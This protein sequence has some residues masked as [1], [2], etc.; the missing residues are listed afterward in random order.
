LATNG[1]K[2]E[3]EREGKGQGK[4]GKKDM[5]WRKSRKYNPNYGLRLMIYFTA[6]ARDIKDRER[7]FARFAVA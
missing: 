2:A 1:K 7:Q 3:K 6:S 5:E 4:Q